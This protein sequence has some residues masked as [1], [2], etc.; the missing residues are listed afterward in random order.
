MTFGQQVIAPLLIEFMEQHPN[1][2]TTTELCRNP[3]NSRLIL[4][5][6]CDG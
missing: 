6:D 1:L 2:D 5:R 3:S 4:M